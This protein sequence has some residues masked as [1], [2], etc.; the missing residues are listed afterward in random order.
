MFM[1]NKG[2]DK[3]IVYLLVIAGLLFGSLAGYVLAYFD[4]EPRLGQKDGQLSTYMDQLSDLNATIQDLISQID[5]MNTTLLQHENDISEYLMEIS[6]L[7]DV[8]EDQSKLISNLR[9]QI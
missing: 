5:P 4:L 3:N 6:E 1:S 8:V 2:M 7:N 9:E